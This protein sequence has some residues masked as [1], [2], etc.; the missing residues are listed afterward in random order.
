MDNLQERIGSQAVMSISLKAF[1]LLAC[2]KWML[3]VAEAMWAGISCITLLGSMN[4]PTYALRPIVSIDLKAGGYTITS[5]VNE[6][7]KMMIK[8]E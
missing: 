8:L 1:V 2:N 5:E 6:D 7:G 4:S 3:I